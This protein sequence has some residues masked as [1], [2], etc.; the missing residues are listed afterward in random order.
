[1]EMRPCLSFGFVLPLQRVVWTVLGSTAVVFGLGV[2]RVVTGLRILGSGAGAHLPLPL[3]TLEL[4]FQKGSSF[5]L[6]YE[7]E[8]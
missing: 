5:G 1:M 3:K 2:W 8:F 6:A 7:K 4:S